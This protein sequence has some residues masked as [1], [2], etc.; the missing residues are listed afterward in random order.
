ML[1]GIYKAFRV[2][3]NPEKASVGNIILYLICHKHGVTKQ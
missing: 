1:Q 3:L 2:F